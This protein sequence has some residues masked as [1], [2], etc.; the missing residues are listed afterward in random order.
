VGEG[1][2]DVWMLESILAT[3]KS[4][5]INFDIW[6][7]DPIAGFLV[8]VILL[9]VLDSPFFLFF[10]APQPKPQGWQRAAEPENKKTP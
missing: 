7:L 3:V 2:T 9:P 6:G 4:P 10:P 8:R 1:E 5:N